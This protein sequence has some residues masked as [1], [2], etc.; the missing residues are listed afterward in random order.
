MLANELSLKWSLLHQPK[1]GNSQAEYEDA[2]AADP[3]RARFAVAD[4]ASESAF[5]SL[6]ARALTEAFVGASH[7]RRLAEWVEIPRGRW[8]S[9]VGSLEL[10]WYAEVKREEGAF[11]TLLGVTIDPPSKGHLG[12]WRGLAVGDSCLV[13]VRNRQHMR[14]FPIRQSAEF[15]NQPSLLPSR[16]GAIPALRRSSG[17]LHFGDQVFLMTDALAQWFL[18]R[19]E[20]G[21]RPWEALT[22]VL[23]ADHPEAAFVDWVEK[24]R[25]DGRIRNDDVTLL[26]IE[27]G[28][29]DEEAVS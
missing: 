24:L 16:R 4:G 23:S 1:C 26:T 27:M 28:A 18:C 17:S 8:A 10:P 5:A 19:H 21:E 14:S 3:M 2:W 12:Q 9:E 6:W 29:T 20:Q 25:I 22:P 13:R 11:A 15:G 7:P